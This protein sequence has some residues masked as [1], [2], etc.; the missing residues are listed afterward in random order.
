MPAAPRRQHLGV[1]RPYVKEATGDEIEEERLEL[2]V[3]YTRSCMEALYPVPAPTVNTKSKRPLPQAHLPSPPPPPATSTTL[4]V[5]KPHWNVFKRHG[6]SNK[7]ASSSAGFE[8]GPR[9][10]RNERP[11]MCCQRCGHSLILHCWEN[12][13]EKCSEG[14]E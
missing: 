4:S 14:E 10:P 7:Q 3:T 13:D 5:G 11:P 6:S 9:N 1:R 8:M 2:I 12:T